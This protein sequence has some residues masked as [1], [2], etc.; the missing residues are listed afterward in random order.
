MLRT[1]HGTSA[2][3]TG[4]DTETEASRCPSLP[5]PARDN[6]KVVDERSHSSCQSPRVDSI[7][8]KVEPLVE[9]R[10]RSS[11]AIGI[12]IVALGLRVLD[13]VLF[14][15][16]PTDAATLAG[17]AEWCRLKES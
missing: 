16:S 17:T 9:E 11:L 1:S 12:A 7:P 2:N 15:L 5:S 10:R 3:G 6:V 14:G 4:E 13:G 8:P